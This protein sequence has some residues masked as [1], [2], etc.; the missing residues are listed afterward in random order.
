MIV[1]DPATGEPTAC[2]STARALVAPP[3]P[4]A[5]ARDKWLGPRSPSRPP[6]A[7]R[8]FRTWA[9]APRR[10]TS[11]ARGPARAL[12]RAAR[13]ALPRH[14]EEGM[15]GAADPLTAKRMRLA[16]PTT[17][18]VGGVVLR[19]R[20]ARLGAAMLAPYDDMPNATARSASRPRPSSATRPR[21]RGR[22]GSSRRTP[23]ATPRTGSCSTRT[24]PSPRPAGARARRPRVEHAQLVNCTDLPR[25]PRSAC[26]PRCSRRAARR[27]SR[28]PS[29]ASGPSAARAAR[30]RGFGARLGGAPR[31]AR[32]FG[33]SPSPFDGMYAAVT[34]E[35]FYGP[36]LGTP[37]GGWYPT[38]AEPRAGAA[39]LHVRRGV[40]RQPRGRARLARRGQARGF[41]RRRPRPDD[42]DAR[43]GDPRDAG[44]RDLP[45]REARR[46][47]R[48]RARGGSGGPARRAALGH[49]RRSVRGEVLRP[50]PP[51]AWGRWDVD[52]YKAT[53]AR[54]RGEVARVL[55]A[56]VDTRGA[57]AVSRTTMIASEQH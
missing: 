48:R 21:G 7:S 8:P 39:R 53:H 35:V 20:R 51:R 29:S 25:S 50:P 6:R 34:R 15:G 2:S 49:S 45:R 23:S 26:S 14:A 24:R 46:R 16:G 9:R 12:E 57:R 32:T 55:E 33:S 10:S 56:A 3:T 37:E 11:S 22:A 47:R 4:S 52:M 31:S 18:T 27:T 19:R 28:S 1:R 41:R 5:A 17:L 40:R 30:T 38:S 13:R 44:A 43:R 54:E 42:G 36:D